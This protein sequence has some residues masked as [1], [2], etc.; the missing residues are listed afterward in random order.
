ML[1]AKDLV[2]K[3]T[4]ELLEDLVDTRKELFDAKMSFHARQLDNA[5]SMKNSKKQIARILTVIREKELEE[6]GN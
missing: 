5:A 6:E 1:K 3:T 2:Q 4:D